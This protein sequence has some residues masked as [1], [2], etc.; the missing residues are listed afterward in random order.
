MRTDLRV[1]HDI[2]VRGRAAALF[3]SGRGYKSVAASSPS[4]GAP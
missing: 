1:K 3:S 2:G 4:L